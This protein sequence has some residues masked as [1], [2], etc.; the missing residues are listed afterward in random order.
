MQLDE[1]LAADGLLQYTLVWVPFPAY[2]L[3]RSMMF[4]SLDLPLSQFLTATYTDSHVS[5]AYSKLAPFF[6]SLL[7]QGVVYTLVVLLVESSPALVN[8]M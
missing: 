4:L 1:D 8:K 7:V 6:L 2:A 5:N 3:G